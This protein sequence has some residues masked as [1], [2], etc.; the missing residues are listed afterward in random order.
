VGGQPAYDP[1]AYSA[2]SCRV[3]GLH[4]T[5]A[6]VTPTAPSLF[7]TLRL[8]LTAA[9][10]IDRGTIRTAAEAL[11][12]QRR[13]HL[14][15]SPVTRLRAFA[16]GAGQ[17]EKERLWMPARRGRQPGRCDLLR[18]RYPRAVAGMRRSNAKFLAEPLPGRDESLGSPQCRR[19]QAGR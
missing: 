19:R 8:R 5:R 2:R 6:Q 16:F 13:H 1:A 10:M 4:R 9:G 14:L 7:G 3:S 18:G 12:V 15:Q 17:E 11:W